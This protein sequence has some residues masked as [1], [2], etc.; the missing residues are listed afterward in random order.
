MSGMSL[1]RGLASMAVCLILPA[2]GWGQTL[3]DGPGK[4]TFESVCSVCHS[5]VAVV[6][7]HKTRAEWQAKVNEMLQAQTDVSTSD[8]TT[9]VEYLAKNFPP[10]KINVNKAA[11]AELESALGISG[12]DAAAI[13]EYRAANGNYKTADDLKKVPGIDTTKIEAG[14]QL[15]E[16]Q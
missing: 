12:K 16:F 4:D 8:R 14:R 6:G 9:I 7:Q 15:I 5:P 1:A 3:P 10:E 11:A 2:A 13:V